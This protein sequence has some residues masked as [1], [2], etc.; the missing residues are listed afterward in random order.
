[1]AV[2]LTKVP[3]LS[4]FQREHVGT[5]VSGHSGILP[6]QKQSPGYPVLPNIT[7]RVNLPSHGT[8]YLFS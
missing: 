7:P 2:N 3:G 8:F 4:Q 5:T 1:M 6:F